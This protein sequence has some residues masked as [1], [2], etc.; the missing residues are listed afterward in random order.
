MFRRTVRGNPRTRPA[1]RAGRLR[2]RFWLHPYA[3]AFRRELRTL[4]RPPGYVR[5]ALV[6]KAAKEEALDKY[7]L[8]LKISFGYNSQNFLDLLI[9]LI[10]L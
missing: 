5:V 10:I 4:A 8:D 2:V 1:L 3:L 6:I 7:F 9:N